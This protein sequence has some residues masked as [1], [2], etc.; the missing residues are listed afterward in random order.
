M[1]G[2]EQE[3]DLWIRGARQASPASSLCRRELATD[4]GVVSFREAASADRRQNPFYKKNVAGR[5]NA[6]HREGRTHE[7]PAKAVEPCEAGARRRKRFARQPAERRDRLGRSAADGAALCRHVLNLGL[8]ERTVAD[9]RGAT[10]RTV[11]AVESQTQKRD[12]REDAGQQATRR[13]ERSEKAEDRACHG[14]IR[15]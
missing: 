13:Q 11:G 8:P 9:E 2:C 12:E 3:A 4:A 7:A 6:E 1:H 5:P 10:D 14:G 15:A